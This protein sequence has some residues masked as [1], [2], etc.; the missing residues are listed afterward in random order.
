M[1]SIGPCKEDVHS[2]EDRSQGGV[3][4]SKSGFVQL[5]PRGSAH[6]GPRLDPTCRLAFG[7]FD[8]ERAAW[9]KPRS[10]RFTLITHGSAPPEERIFHRLQSQKGV[11]VFT[12]LYSCY[13][14]VS[15]TA[16][17][18]SC[19]T[20]ISSRKDKDALFIL[21]VSVS[22]LSKLN[23][24]LLYL[25]DPL[26]SPPLL[27]CVFQPSV[28]SSSMGERDM[29]AHSFSRRVWLHN[30]QICSC[31]S[32]PCWRE[33][34][35][36]CWCMHVEMGIR[37]LCWDHMPPPHPIYNCYISLTCVSG[38]RC[39][40]TAC[41]VAFTPPESEKAELILTHRVSMHSREK[42]R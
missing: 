41:S 22:A 38:D 36:V 24:A 34:R 4:C 32:H 14:A 18:E 12:C 39:F 7:C 20:G 27:S 23:P 5:F 1:S 35:A 8:C 28:Y 33:M 37:R 31:K 26:A 17:V 9:R 10:N 21:F 3:R 11:T 42:E 16:A 2:L 30:E 40:L 13:F 25:S 15:L 6:S 29:F 19:F